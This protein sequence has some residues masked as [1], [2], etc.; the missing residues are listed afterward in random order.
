MASS[1]SDEMLNKKWAE[2]KFL[3][4]I[5]S[6]ACCRFNQFIWSLFAIG[7][8]GVG[9]IFGLFGFSLIVNLAS[10]GNTIIRD[11]HHRE[12]YYFSRYQPSFRQRAKGRYSRP[13]G[14]L[15]VNGDRSSLRTV[16]DSLRTVKWE[17]A[18]IPL[19]WRLFQLARYQV[20][21]LNSFNRC[22]LLKTPP[23]VCFQGKRYPIKAFEGFKKSRAQWDTPCPCFALTLICQKPC[24][25]TALN[26]PVHRFAKTRGQLQDHTDRARVLYLSGQPGNSWRVDES[27][28]SLDY[29]WYGASKTQS[30][31]ATTTETAV[32]RNQGLV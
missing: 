12:L 24:T 15:P 16:N 5:F 30:P 19:L 25:T 7:V 17:F 1:R 28:L 3:S 27:T 22:W 29:P 9:A 2:K 14:A 23:K 4:V 11:P 21:Y 31:R 10:A 13:P 6:Q 18:F 32:G 8:G 20:S 26:W